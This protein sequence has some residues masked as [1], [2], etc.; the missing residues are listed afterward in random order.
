MLPP[1]SSSGSDDGSDISGETHLTQDT[2]IAGVDTPLGK[3]VLVLRGMTATEAMGRLPTFELDLLS[4]QQTLDPKD[5]LGKPVS[6]WLNV[7]G[8]RKRY[9]HGYVVQFGRSGVA[10]RF[11]PYKAVVSPWMWFLTR[12]RNCRIFQNLSVRDIIEKIFKEHGFPYTPRL[13]GDYTTWE[14]CVQYRESDFDFVSRLMEQEGIYYYYDYEENENT[15]VLADSEGAHDPMPGY[16]SID[17]RPPGA[18]TAGEEVREHIREFVREMNHVPGTFTHTDYNFET[19]QADLRTSSTAPGDYPQ[20]HLE[21]YDY[22]G[23]YE[24]HGEGEDWARARLE[25]ITAEAVVYTGWGDTRGLGSGC[26][27]ELTEPPDPGQA[28]QYLVT[29]AKHTLNTGQFEVGNSDERPVYDVHFEVQPLTRIFRAGRDTEKPFIRGL[30]T[31]VVTGPAGEEVYTDNY[32]RVKVQ[33]HWDREGKLDENTTCFVRVASLWAGRR[34]GSSG[35]S[36]SRR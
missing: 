17:Y 21:I 2:R 22:P 15:L 10:S 25:E 14:Y 36:G 1:D 27:F 6:I 34:W 13:T 23:E 31:A 28:G 3:D 33:F 26:C 20:S 35:S 24:K 19:P 9:F 30:Q 8:G 5:L 4:E 32:G 16:E 11:F 29:S 7:L 18:G 12:T